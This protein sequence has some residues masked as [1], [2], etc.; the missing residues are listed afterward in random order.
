[1]PR[2]TYRR[3]RVYR[4]KRSTRR[5]RRRGKR[6]NVSMVR[7]R[8][9]SNIP[10][11]LLTKLKYSQNVILTGT[12]LAVAVFRGNSLFDP[13]LT[14]VG[15]QPKG[16]DQWAAL[17]TRYK[18]YA[19]SVRIIINNNDSQPNVFACI[20]SVDPS[21]PY[22]NITD[23]MEARYAK[24]K[25][26]SPSG[27]GPVKFLK[28]YSTT[29]SIRGERIID[30]DYSALTTSNPTKQWYWLLFGS[31]SDSTGAPNLNVM[32]TITYYCEFMRPGKIPAS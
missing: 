3:K 17:Y 26:M 7:V 10:D 6:S 2:K 9:V 11:K 8:G 25:F 21:T 14:G 30:D 20:P 29:K 1:M 4:K 5:F 16:F 31:T 22:S 27:Q 18:V 24:Y 15:H 12:G 23:V 13:D 32:V 28:S 19:G